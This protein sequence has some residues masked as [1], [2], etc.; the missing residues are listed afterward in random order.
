[1]ITRPDKGSGVV[2]LDKTFYKEKILKL[3]S[4]VNKFKKLNED[5]TLTREE[6]LQLFLRIIKDKGLLDDKTYKKIY[7]SGSKPATI[8]GLP[9]THKLL[10]KDL[11]DLYF[12]PI[13]SSTATYNYNLAKFLSELLNPVIPNEHCAKD[14][15]TLCEE[16]QG[17]TANDYF[18]VS[19]D[20]CSLFTSIP[21]TEIIEI[22]VELIFQN[23]PNL[24]IS[25]NELKQLFKC[26]TSGTH[27][28]FKGNF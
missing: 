10:S 23:K 19:C 16:I 12:C 20:V 15:F 27:F 26:A 18:L 13:V 25:K 14:S 11:P 22:A 17:V 7:S 4:D 9:K 2:I 1:M 3:I 24:K 28:L 21:L 8:Y 5:P 6:Q